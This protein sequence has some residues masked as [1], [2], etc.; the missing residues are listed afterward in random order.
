MRLNLGA[1]EWMLEGWENIDITGPDP[2][3]LTVHPWPF[4]DA[5][6]SEILASH[7]LEHFDH[8][9]AVIFLDECKRI[10]KPGGTLHIAVPDM[11]KFID[12]LNAGDWTPLAGYQWRD[13]NHF[14]GGDGSEPRPEMRHKY[15]WCWGSL[16]YPLSYRFAEVKL[17]DGPAAFDNPRYAPIS[18]Y[19][20]AV[21]ASQGDE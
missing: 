14:M 7:V 16:Y 2:V 19:V 3:D 17:R 1:G 5:S 8:Y 9:Q 15:M 6:A 18:L 11:D 4:S 10:L 12:C 20:D 21:K 13:L